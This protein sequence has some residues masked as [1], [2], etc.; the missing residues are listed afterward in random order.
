M[1]RYSA[2][3]SAKPAEALSRAVEFFG[4]KGAGLRLTDRGM[5]HVRLDHQVG[6]VRIEAARIPDGLTELDIETSGF[7]REVRQF[8]D[9]LPSESSWGR[10]RSLLRRLIGR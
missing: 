3:T 1:A 10:L 5:T 8:I 9:D 4:P 6:H 7:D 2:F